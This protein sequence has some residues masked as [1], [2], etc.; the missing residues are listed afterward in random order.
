[1]SARGDASKAPGPSELPEA[2]DVLEADGLNCGRLEPLIA[3]RL[4]AL[5]PGQV[6]EVRSDQTAAEDGIAAWSWL[7]GNALVAIA[8]EKPP[9]ARYYV[10]KQ[11]PKV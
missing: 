4:R 1:V 8:R 11:A 3:E 10:R 7:S 9:R 2:D 6:L 5:A